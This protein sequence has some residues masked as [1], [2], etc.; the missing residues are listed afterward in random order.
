MGSIFGSILGLI[1]GFSIGF[2]IGFNNGFNIG[3]NIRFN[4]W[5]NIG[6]NMTSF[7]ITSLWHHL[8]WQMHDPWWVMHDA[9]CNT[10]VDLIFVRTVNIPSLSLLTFLR[11]GLKFFLT[12]KTKQTNARTN[13]A[14]HWGTMLPKIPDQVAKISHTKKTLKNWF[15][16]ANNPHE[17]A[18]T[19]F[20]CVY[21]VAFSIIYSFL[22]NNEK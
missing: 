1:L 10:L 9:L 5:F 14:I 4:I 12:H 21:F 6:F 18:P 17:V 15:C 7:G 11:S 16:W 22:P 20:L 8:S 2:N 19:F 3:L 13:K